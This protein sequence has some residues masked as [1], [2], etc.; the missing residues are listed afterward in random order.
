MALRVMHKLLRPF[1]DSL[2]QLAVPAHPSKDER[3]HRRRNA[4]PEGMPQDIDLEFPLLQSNAFLFRLL[5]FLL[6]PLLL[7]LGL[8]PVPE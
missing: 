3:N 1:Q 7:R 8:Q 4:A 5:L 6:R 2:G